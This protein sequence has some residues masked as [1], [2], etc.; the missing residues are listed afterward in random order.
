MNNTA[1][2]SDEIRSLNDEELDAV[3]GGMSVFMEQVVSHV[4][5]YAWLAD[6]CA[7]MKC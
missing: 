4:E 2:Q 1:K 7:F 5:Y 3:T 6:Y